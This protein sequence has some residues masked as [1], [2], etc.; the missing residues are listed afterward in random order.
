ML[1]KKYLHYCEVK[2]T[3]TAAISLAVLVIIFLIPGLIPGRY[4]A[5]VNIYNF[6]APYLDITTQMLPWYKLSSQIIHAGHFPFWNIFSGNGLPLF[7]NMQAAVF[8]PLTWLF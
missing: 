8:Y 4:L 5:P 6:T 1:I 2:P 3:L 7:A